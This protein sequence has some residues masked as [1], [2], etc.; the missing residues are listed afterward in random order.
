[1]SIFFIYFLLFIKQEY[2]KEFDDFT[3]AINFV[4]QK[5]KEFNSINKSVMNLIDKA[6]EKLNEIDMTKFDLSQIRLDDVNKLI[7]NINKQLEK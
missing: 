1:M 7:E 3:Q 5:V 2:G 4:T 6:T